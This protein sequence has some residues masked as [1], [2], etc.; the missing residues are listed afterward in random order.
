[1]L[2]ETN[3]LIRHN[4]H[5]VLS[6]ENFANAVNISAIGNVF[7]GDISNA[8]DAS[9]TV[10]TTAKF[11]GQNIELGNQVNDAVNF[12]SLTLNAVADALVFEDSDLLLT[13][14]SAA[15]NLRLDS[16]GNIRDSAMSVLNVTERAKFTAGAAGQAAIQV[17]DGDA[18]FEAGSLVFNTAGDV[19]I[20]QDNAMFLAGG[21][22]FQA[23]NSVLLFGDLGVS[24][25]AYLN[26]I[27]QS[28]LTIG[29]N[30]AITLGTSDT[31]YLAFDGLNF[32]S[33]ASGVG[34]TEI[35]ANSAILLVGANSAPEFRVKSVTVVPENG[36]ISNA[37]G[38]HL[39]ATTFARFE[40]ADINIGT[41]AGDCFHVDTGNFEAVSLTG[42][43]NV[44]H[45]DLCLV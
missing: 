20:Y 31:D 42:V 44:I 43:V 19:A 3:F 33:G 32:N 38:A 45:D 15:F 29:S 36:D 5:L 2:E 12:G 10:A 16:T 37:P 22:E 24:A 6:G 40:G 39:V 9:L 25:A 14:T 21:G 17:G 8:A 23:G 26:L 4:T 34:N 28:T 13:G 11:S 1:M 41:E 35:V 18:M 27:A 30:G 7:V